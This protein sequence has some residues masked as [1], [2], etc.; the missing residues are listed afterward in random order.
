[1]S[2]ISDSIFTVLVVEDEQIN[3]NNDEHI[4]LNPINRDF[5]GQMEAFGDGE[6]DCRE[7]AVQVVKH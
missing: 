5:K 2:Y 3:W 7:G 1:M 4:M 6:E